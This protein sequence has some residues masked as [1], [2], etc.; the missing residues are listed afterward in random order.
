MSI[1]NRP[2][3]PTTMATRFGF[4]PRP[5]APGLH[6]AQASTFASRSRS[7]SPTSHISAN[8]SSSSLSSQRLAKAQT[9]SKPTSNRSNPSSSSTT[10]TNNNTT[11][12][13]KIL[14]SPRQGDSSILKSNVKSTIQAP[15]ATSLMR[16]RTPSRT[17]AT[18]SSS[19]IASPPHPSSGPLSSQTTATTTTTTTT[20]I[21][22]DVNAIRD[23]YRTQKRMNFF[24][25]HTPLS[26][27]NGSPVANS[28]Q[29]PKT[30]V[31][32]QENK[33]SSSSISS[34]TNN[35]NHDLKA[36]IPPEIPSSHHNDS[37]YANV[38][39]T[40]NQP[41]SAHLSQGNRHRQRAISM[42]SAASAISDVLN[43]DTL[44]EDD[45]CSLKSDDL[46]CD[47]DDTLTIDSTSKNDRIDS[48]SLASFSN[49]TNKQQTKTISVTPAKPNVPHYQPTSKEHRSTTIAKCSTN[50]NDKTNAS[51]RESLD[52]LNRLSNRMDHNIDNEQNRRLLTRS[53]SLKPPPNYLPPLEDAEQITMD[54]ESYRQVM[55]DVMVVKT[56]LHQLDRLLKH[57]DGANM[58]DSMIGSIHEYHDP[59]MSSRRFST[60]LADGNVRN[61]IDEHSSYD[62]L[63]KEIATLRKEKEQDKQT[64]KLL[65]EQMYKYSSQ[66]NG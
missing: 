66:T 64:I 30:L 21:K 5:T 17:S 44:L 62:D 19:S 53:V 13:P 25:R 45:N 58:T 9:I 4:I 52:E 43:Q 42:L 11:S 31:I 55:K 47:F 33:Q 18:S 24:T 29:S 63:L 36:V 10:T 16:S 41:P 60:S 22:T 39:S 14:T 3:P 1:T 6:Q 32:N 65:Q 50:T 20:I 54:I 37:T 26:T 61:G 23:R 49:E 38:K 28:I 46:M 12:K 56:I 27:A 15:T 48:H 7:I 40:S 2:S 57:S 8:S 59:M 51:L 35:L 34:T